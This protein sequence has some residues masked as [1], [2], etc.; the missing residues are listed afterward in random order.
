MSVSRRRAG[1][2]GVAALGML[3]AVALATEAATPGQGGDR[4]ARLEAL[5]AAQQNKIAA[6]EQRLAA[7]GAQDQDAARVEAMRQ[8]IREILSEQ[9]FRESL[10]PSVMLAGYDKGFYIR[11]SDDKFKL[12]ING[13]MQ[14]RWTH[15][16]TQSRNKY[17]MPRYERN[18]RTGFDLQ[19]VRLIF[20]GHAWTPDLTYHLQV[21]MDSARNYGASI[22]WAYLNYRFCDAFQVRAGV[23]KLASTRSQ[24]IAEWGFQFVDRTMTDAVFSFGN[25]LGVR[26]WGHL[27]DKQLTYMLDVVNS[28]NSNGNRTITNDPAEM[29]NNPAILFR[30]VWHALGDD[31]KE[32]LFEGDVNKL[33]SPALDIGFWYAFNEDEYDSRTTRIPF[34]VER[35]APGIGG[36]GLTNTNGL[37]INQF[38][39]DAAFK[40]QGF[41][42]QA[43][44]YLR[45]VDPRRAG[46][47]P[48][49][50]W[51]LLTRQA[52][53]T[54]QHGA[55]L[56]V[57]YFLPIPG[58]ED[59]LEA[60]ARVGGISALAND[61]EGVWEYAAGLN[62]YLR[63]PEA[64]H[65]AKLQ[66][67]VTKIYEAPISN[68]Y[69]SLAN[70]N[71]N[72]LIFRV[73]LQV[74]F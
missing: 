52:D 28:L 58:Y 24:L 36:F 57:G 72:A 20:S 41:S 53:T 40:Y 74:G 19:R 46:R 14:F 49:T 11:S 59:K 21:N 4:V 2:F 32:W 48:F 71:D 8:Q 23:F 13:Y 33:Q 3:A 9:E 67:D 68:P 64:G 7:A 60:V 29:D 31:L 10:M 47:R 16:D 34:P 38:G 50:P 56:Q 70:V 69:V 1:M 12:K 55:Y 42:A 5:L 66:F 6:L 15:Y 22:H 44:Y 45:I 73:Q 26:F 65:K 51:W 63:G 18:D 30:L 27:L 25:G 62:Y 61:R 39:F 17:L 35:R 37:Q 43:E 54:V